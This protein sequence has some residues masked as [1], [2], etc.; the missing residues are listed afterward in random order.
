MVS[1]AD[2]RIARLASQPTPRNS[3]KV[4]LLVFTPSDGWGPLCRFLE[5]PVPAGESAGT[6]FGA[7]CIGT[8]AAR[9][10]T[11]AAIPRAAF[12]GIRC[13]QDPR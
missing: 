12:C 7:A 4:G 9:H 5:L 11:E 13:R 3:E 8:A 2:G 6:A 10:C 1:L